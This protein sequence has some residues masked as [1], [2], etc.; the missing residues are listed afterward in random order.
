R[1]FATYPF[2]VICMALIRWS[3]VRTKI[4]LIPLIGAVGFSAFLA[5]SAQSTANNAELLQQTRDVRVPMLQTAD[6]LSVSLDRVTEGLS[7]AVSAGDADMLEAA[8]A[9]AGQIRQDLKQLPSLDT[10]SKAEVASLARAVTRSYVEGY[11]KSMGLTVS[12]L[13]L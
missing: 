1:F 4:L 13:P 7:S 9:V 3:S 6:R 10:A 8:R 12:S 2:K 11:D 5:L